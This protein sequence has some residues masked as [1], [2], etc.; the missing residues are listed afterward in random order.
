MP[1]VS[2]RG[3]KRQSSKPEMKYLRTY[4]YVRLSEKDGGH[5]RRD[6]IYIQNRSVKTTQRNTRKCWW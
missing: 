2:K 1:K 3:Q 6:S 4:I 5:G